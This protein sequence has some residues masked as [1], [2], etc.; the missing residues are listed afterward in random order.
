MLATD[1]GDQH[2]AGAAVDHH[3]QDQLREVDDRLDVEPDHLELLLEVV[4]EERAADADAGIEQQ[5]IDV[6]AAIDDRL[7]ELLAAV[8]HRQIGLHRQDERAGLAEVLRGGLDAVILRADDEVEVLL[9]ALAGELEADARRRARDDRQLSV[10][11]ATHFRLLVVARSVAS[12]RTSAEDSQQRL[13]TTAAAKHETHQRDPDERRRRAWPP[14]RS[15]RRLRRRG[16]HA[17]PARGEAVEARSG[18]S[19]RCRPCSPC[20]ICCPCRP[21]R[22]RRSRSRRCRCTPCRRRVGW[23]GVMM[24]W[25]S[26]H[27]GPSEQ[28][29]SVSQ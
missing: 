5:R 13:A 19:S 18:S 9:D 10:G 11:Y 7:I 24:H 21:S 22:T 4:D 25:F 1:A 29:A 6:P 27:C 12:S 2:A 16:Q 3:R 28:S 8:V 20:C 17:P 15:S 23:N 26:K 14:H